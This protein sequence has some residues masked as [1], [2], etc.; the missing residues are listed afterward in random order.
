MTL[1]MREPGKET[2]GA[3]LTCSLRVTVTKPVQRRL[4]SGQQL[5]LF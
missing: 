1:R 5:T 2:A 4:I 3:V